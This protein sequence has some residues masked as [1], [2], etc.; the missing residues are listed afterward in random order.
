MTKLLAGC[1]VSLA[2]LAGACGSDGS[3]RATSGSSVDRSSSEA[4]DGSDDSDQT[5][6]D[7]PEEA[8]EV[9]SGPLEIVLETTASTAMI[10]PDGG[11]VEVTSSA[12]TV[13]SL[14]VPKDALL[15]DVEITATPVASIGNLGFDAHGVVFGP[16]GL[17]FLGTAQLTI[18]PTEAVPV[19]RQLPLM[20]DDT[21]EQFGVAEPK[22]DASAV[23]ILVQHFSGYA[24][25]DATRPSQ[26]AFAERQASDAETRIS[27]HFAEILA[28]ERQSQLLEGESVVDLAE[29]FDKFGKE[30]EEQVIKPR[31]AAANSS[32]AAAGRAISTVL[33]YERQRQLLGASGEFFIGDIFDLYKQAFPVCEEEAITKCKGLKDPSILL[34]FWITMN[35]TAQL[36]GAPDFVEVDIDK[37]TRICT[38]AAYVIAGGLDDFQVNQMVCDIMEPFELSGGGITMTF[39][40]GLAGSYSYS[41]GPFNATGSGTY[42]ISLPNGP[43]EPGSMVGNGT[44]SVD[45]PL[46]SFEASGTETY[47]LA[48]VEPCT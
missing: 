22:L 21:G 46:G 18:T 8:V 16:S 38:P 25:G 9:L 42:T 36:F 39:T 27:S 37:A 12:G 15:G 28:R 43:S 41:G 24:F 2:L 6:G 20:F 31:L 11:T 26:A 35:R 33:G 1:V 5:A 34:Q 3:P 44:G 40:G 48:P 23:V 7:V 32:C 30:Y 4:G 29:E 13:F 10:G 45:T 17:S 14:A 47:S 19:D